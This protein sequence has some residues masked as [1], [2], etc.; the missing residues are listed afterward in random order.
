MKIFLLGSEGQL[1]SSIKKKFSKN[2]N[3][4]SYSR[5]EL[6]INNLSK[7]SKLI[8]QHKPDII[9]N[10]AAYTNVDAAEKN[11]VQAFYINSNCLIGLS[12][13]CSTENIILIHSLKVSYE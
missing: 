5:K 4:I 11:K 6:D 2:I 1:G 9:I 13:I 7:L 10:A 12:K 3:L 8:V